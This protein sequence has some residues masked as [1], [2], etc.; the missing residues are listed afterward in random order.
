MTAFTSV[1]GT[2]NGFATEPLRDLMAAVPAELNGAIFDASLDH[3]MAKP[4]GAA[5]QHWGAAGRFQAALATH[6]EAM[7]Q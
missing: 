5:G 1:L 2:L 3:S 4:W 7:A 6:E